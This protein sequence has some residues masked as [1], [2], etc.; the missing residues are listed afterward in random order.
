MR[1]HH[2][3]RDQANWVGLYGG[4]VAKKLVSFGDARWQHHQPHTDVV[5]QSPEETAIDI[6]PEPLQTVAWFR[7]GY[8]DNGVYLSCGIANNVAER[9]W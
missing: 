8:E 4:G 3:S 2:K 9:A 1:S 7:H 6:S 5:E